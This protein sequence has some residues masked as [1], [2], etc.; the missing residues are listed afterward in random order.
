MY[1]AEEEEEETERQSRRLES[2][3]MR[4]G[5]T[6]SKEGESL[7]YRIPNIRR[8]KYKTDPGGGIKLSLLSGY[9]S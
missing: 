5:Y 2:H 8:L 4:P 7:F 9:P 3:L 6:L 1:K